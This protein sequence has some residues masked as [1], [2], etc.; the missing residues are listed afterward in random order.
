MKIAI[1]TDDGKSVRKGHFAESRLFQVFT[2]LNGQI[3]GSEY[4]DSA[5]KTPGEPAD[6]G[7]THNRADLLKDCDIYLG[8][9]M[10]R[11]SM[12]KLTARHVDCILT[13]YESIQDTVER[14]LQGEDQGF[15]FFDEDTDTLRPCRERRKILKNAAQR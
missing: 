6:P 5:A 10:D 11:A 13:D 4:R 1:G 7:Q 8:R 15:W 3:A 12:E 2:V 14:F 9:S